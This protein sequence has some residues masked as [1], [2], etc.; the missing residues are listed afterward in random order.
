MPREKRNVV[1]EQLA[2]EA[3]WVHAFQTFGEEW[4]EALTQFAKTTPESNLQAAI[5][6]RGA[7]IDFDEQQVGIAWR[8]GAALTDAGGKLEIKAPSDLWMPR[9]KKKRIG[10]VR[11][12]RIAL[13]DETTDILLDWFEWESKS[14]ARRAARQ[15]IELFGIYAAEYYDVHNY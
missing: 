2:R 12:L 7:Y 11:A 3:K 4:L 5:A 15:S 14:D 10:F 1:A 6:P 13:I 9:Y 8:L